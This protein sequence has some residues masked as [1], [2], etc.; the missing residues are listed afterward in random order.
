M[1]RAFLFT[2]LFTLPF[3]AV[4]AADE[5][6]GVSDPDNPRVFFETDLGRIT[7]E[8]Y[9]KKAPITVAN[10]LHY[11]DTG[12]YVGTIFHRVID[13]FVIQGG[14]YTFDFKRKEPAAPIKNEADNKLLNYKATLSMARTANPDSATSQFF[15]NIKHNKNLDQGGGSAGYAVFAKVVE[16]FEVVKK[17]EREPRGLYRAHPEAPNYPV[18]ILK[19][20]RVEKQTQSQ[21]QK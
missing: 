16:G 8:L 7:I 1:L 10:F 12:F 13:D 15:I 21:E 17:V 6:K 18:R 5:N 9:P 19:A 14:G 11:V 3:S 20:G 4:Y 2:L